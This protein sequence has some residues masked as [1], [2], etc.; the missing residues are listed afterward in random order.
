LIG[1]VVAV[2]HSIGEKVFFDW[3]ASRTA[4]TSHVHNNP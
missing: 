2:L 1:Q 3:E 4:L